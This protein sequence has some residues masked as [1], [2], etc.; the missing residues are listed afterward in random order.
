V[1]HCIEPPMST[2]AAYSGFAVDPAVAM[3]E[4]KREATERLRTLVGDGVDVEVV[5]GSV[6][7]TLIGAAEAHDAE[8]VVCASRCRTGFSRW[9]LGSVAGA[10]IREIDRSVLVVPRR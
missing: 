3:R 1:V 6:V 8:V 10:L 7:P 5:S 9:L 4:A 2:E